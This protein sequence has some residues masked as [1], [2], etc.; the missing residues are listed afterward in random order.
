MAK[1]SVTNTRPGELKPDDEL[2][3]AIKVVI[4]F[5]GNFKVYRCDWPEQLDPNDGDKWLVSKELEAGIIQLMPLL[6]G[7]KMTT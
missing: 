2:M 4:D 1:V 3:I 6:H 7:R 5:R